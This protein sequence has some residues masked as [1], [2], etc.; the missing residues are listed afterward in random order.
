LEVTWKPT[1]EQAFQHAYGWDSHVTVSEF[2]PNQHGYQQSKYGDPFLGIVV[3]FD[4][5]D[6]TKGQM[7]VGLDDGWWRYFAVN[8]S[9][10]E[11]YG[12]YC[13]WYGMT[14][15]KLISRAPRV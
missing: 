7:H 10:V 11:N 2:H 3:L 14:P 9:I 6:P 4:N 12:E 8:G 5:D 15:S 13:H 1:A